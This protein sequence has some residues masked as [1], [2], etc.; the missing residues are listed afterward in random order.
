MKAHGRRG[1][2]IHSFL[3]SGLVES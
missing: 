2:K 3:T 1:D